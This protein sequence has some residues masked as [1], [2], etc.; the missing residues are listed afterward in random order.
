MLLTKKPNRN[1]K[2]P[3]AILHVI[4]AQRERNQAGKE[5]TAAVQHA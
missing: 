2:Q 4:H 3:T 5:A 1:T